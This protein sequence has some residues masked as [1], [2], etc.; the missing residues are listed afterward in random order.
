MYTVNILNIIFFILFILPIFVGAYKSFSK[1]KIESSLI[2]LFEGLEYLL[3]MV[4]SFILTRGIFFSDIGFFKIIHA[5]IPKSWKNFLGD[6]EILTYLI[7]TPI[8]VFL[9]LILFRFILAP[10]YQGFVIPASDNIKNRVE[11]AAPITQTLI[12]GFYQVPKSFTITI[13]YAVILSCFSYYSFIPAMSKFM[14]ESLIYQTVYKFSVYHMLSPNMTKEIAIITDKD[15]LKNKN[16]GDAVDLR[17]GKKL[18][19]EGINIENYLNGQSIKDVTKSNTEIDSMANDII[20]GE[21]DQ[22][23]K[24]RIIYDWIVKNIEFDKDKTEKLSNDPKGISSSAIICFSTK[25]GA[26]FDYTSLYIAMCRVVGVKVRFITGLAYN[27]VSWGTHSW[28]QVQIND[29]K[30]IPVDTTFGEDSDY[31]DKEEFYKDHSDG[32]VREEW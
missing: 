21:K 3:A 5:I 22:K 9:I 20:D 7:V 15:Y 25:K 8:F 27:G 18:D 13:A 4:L 14:N 31:F 28:N 17:N 6:Q 24:A 30:W 12:Y 11:K 19:D 23:K 16:Q 26:C 32:E 2:T 1:D 10:V 29:E